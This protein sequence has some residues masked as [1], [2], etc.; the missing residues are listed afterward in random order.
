MI[1]VY[2]HVVSDD[3]THEK[4]RLTLAFEVGHT[5][6]EGEYITLGA[7]YKITRVTHRFHSMKVPNAL[8]NQK[9]FADIPSL[10]IRLE[11]V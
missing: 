7:L 9:Y 4:E 10:D 2:A 1:V 5:P 11:K 8:E 3:G 6:R